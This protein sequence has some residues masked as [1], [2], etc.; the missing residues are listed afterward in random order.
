MKEKTENSKNIA[1]N[2]IKNREKAITLIALVVTIIVLI[3]LAG[4]SINLVLGDN[5]IITK[6]RDARS[7]FQRAAE[8]EQTNL[9]NLYA[10][11]NEKIDGQ[12]GS[13]AGSGELDS[14]GDVRITEFS[15]AGT[16]VIDVPLPSSDFEKV[17]DTEID[18]SYV[19]RGKAGTTY[20]GDEFVWVPVDK[21]QQFT[22]KIEGSGNITSVVLTNPVGDTKVVASN[23]TAPQNLTGISPTVESSV[24]NGTYKVTVTKSN[25]ETVEQ[26]LDVYS[27]YAFNVK[28]KLEIAKNA[29]GDNYESTIEGMGGPKAVALMYSEPNDNFS[30][31]VEENGGFWIGR[32]EAS[33]N[34]TTTKAASKASTST[35]YDGNTSNLATGMLWNY[36]TRANALTT[37]NSYNSTLNSSLPTGAAWDRTLGWIYEKR[38]STGKDL[39]SITN[40]STGWGNYS[41]DTFSGTDGLINTGA[42]SQTAANNIYDLAGNLAEWTTENC[43]QDGSTYFVRRGGDY[44][45]SGSGRP[46]AGRNGISDS[47][48]YSIGF[49][50]V[51]YK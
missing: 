32:Y 49:R 10:E 11:M 51:L 46:A 17:A 35:N 30:S 25:E 19:A 2:N 3:I 15:I 12:G 22:V 6:A 29:L 34:S 7:N 31:R 24:Y 40:N 20:A 39:A 18:N 5:G 1:R 21:N 44:E 50:L 48:L 14:S 26:E 47:A 28:L 36:I 8:E 42:K 16:P 13:G 38:S 41:D 45:H 9:D 43:T 23:I 33:Y 37:A 27:L 4:V